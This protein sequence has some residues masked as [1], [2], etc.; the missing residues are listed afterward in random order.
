MVMDVTFRE[1][2]CWINVSKI[3]QTFQND[4]VRLYNDVVGCHLCL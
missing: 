2:F 1:H 3:L 4:L